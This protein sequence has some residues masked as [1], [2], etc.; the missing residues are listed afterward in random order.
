[1]DHSIDKRMNIISLTWPIW[2]E[3]ALR[4]TFMS[5]DVFMLSAYSDRAVA[6][7][8]VMS[9]MGFFIIILFMTVSAGAGILISQA[10]GAGKKEKAANMAMAGV[11]MSTV[12]GVI[13][14]ILIRVFTRPIIGV[15]EMESDVAEYA[16][17]YLAIFGSFSFTIALSTIFTSI[18]RSFG[19]SK[20]PM[21]INMAANI[22]NI[23][24]NYLFIFGPFGIPVLGVVG[25]AVSTVVSRGLGAVVMLIIILKKNDIPFEASRVSKIGFQEI[26]H[27]LSLGIPHAGENLS[28]NLAQMVSL[29]AISRMGTASLSAYSYAVSIS[30]FIYLTPFSIGQGSMVLVGYLVGAGQYEEAYRKVFRYYAV[31]VLLTITMAA[32]IAVFRFPITRIFTDDPKIT[33]LT[34]SILLYSLVYEPGRTANLIFVN[35]IKGAGDIKFPV[36]V[37][38]VTMWLLAAGGSYLLGLGLGIGVLGVF[39]AFSADEWIRGFIMFLRWKSRRWERATAGG[40]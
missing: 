23:V 5:V 3:T 20:P 21:Y 27:I 18:L 7:V 19:Y 37:A 26:K 9:Q 31:S 4:M 34:A 39:I 29:W 1:M 24:G 15:F 33:A 38:L 40:L 2:I 32:T 28:F 25:V 10:N 6:A 8:G 22:L 11:L 13:I 16:R 30:R 36:G 14:S 12:F 17:E 35:A